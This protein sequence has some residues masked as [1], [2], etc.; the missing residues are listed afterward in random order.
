M[1]LEYYEPSGI[2][3]FFL[4]IVDRY[5]LRERA[6]GQIYAYV[7][8]WY[9]AMDDEIENA[10]IR[11]FRLAMQKCAD[12]RRPGKKPYQG[13]ARPEGPVARL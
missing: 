8:P 1:A 5:T 2:Q 3:A 13:T 6:F 7:N 9:A 11:F 10:S 12:R 4:K